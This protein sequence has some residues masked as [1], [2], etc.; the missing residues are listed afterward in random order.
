M[1]RSTL[2]VRIV[3]A[4]LS[5]VGSAIQLGL[6]AGALALS[7]AASSAHAAPTPAAALE[8]RYAELD[9]GH[10]AGIAALYG[11]I[12][13]AARLVCGDAQ[14]AGSRFTSPAWEAC[15]AAATEDAVLAVDRPALTAYHAAHKVA[16][17]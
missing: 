15:V 10:P 14:P 4:A 7:V 12:G 16:R 1:D 8:V 6:V 9:L 2:T 11:R 17:T 3:A 13:A 5:V